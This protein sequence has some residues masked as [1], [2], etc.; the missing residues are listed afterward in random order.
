[1]KKWWMEDDDLDS[2]LAQLGDLPSATPIITPE[3]ILAKASALSPA[4]TATGLAGWKLAT[5]LGTAVVAGFG[6]GVVLQEI[7]DDRTVST[8]VEEASVESPAQAEAQSVEQSANDTPLEPSVEET[9]EDATDL[10]P[11]VTPEV[12][13]DVTPEDQVEPPLNLTVVAPQS[14][15]PQQE[16]VI[17]VDND[18]PPSKPRQKNQKPPQRQKS[19]KS[20]PA[21]LQEQS[22]EQTKVV[23]ETLPKQDSLV[24][25][26]PKKKRLVKTTKSTTELVQKSIP[27]KWKV[28]SRLG[29][30]MPVSNPEEPLPVIGVGIA[31]EHGDK[32]FA[33]LASYGELG[34][35]LRDHK[36]FLPSVQLDAGLGRRGEKFTTTVGVGFGFHSLERQ[37]SGM[38]QRAQEDNRQDEQDDPDR[39]RHRALLM[40][41]PQLKIDFGDKFWM[42]SEFQ[43]TMRLQ[44]NEKWLGINFGVNFP[45]GGK[46]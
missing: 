34:M 1:M 30:Q 29:F 26:K 9:P 13:P 12:T 31:Y 17:I 5:A 14:E 45:I 15:R 38:Q 28:E 27:S 33:R 39:S 35:P 22:K 32:Y 24:V 43:R 6:G 21:I 10:T 44:E 7:R 40:A 20:T 11:E 41:G 18:R 3:Q 25:E 23:V 37:G 36:H 46:G 8:V 2:A 16:P 42:M 4:A 19:K